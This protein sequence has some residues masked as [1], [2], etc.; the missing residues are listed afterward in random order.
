MLA[1]LTISTVQ[2]A[3]YAP[4]R[5]GSMFCPVMNRAINEATVYITIAV[6]ADI[7]NFVDVFIF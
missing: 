3:K 2:K 7:T 1:R 6:M 5:A 4:V